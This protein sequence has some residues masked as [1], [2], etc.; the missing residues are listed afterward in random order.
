MPAGVELAQIQQLFHVFQSNV[1]ALRRYRPQV[2]AGQMVFFK[3]NVPPGEPPNTPEADWSKL[4]LSGLDLRGVPGNHYT[5]L[6]E[7]NVENLAE[8]LK[9]QL[10]LADGIFQ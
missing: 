2:Y 3:A 9:Q 6:R 8:Q 7:P 5:I 4:A 1:E 10:H